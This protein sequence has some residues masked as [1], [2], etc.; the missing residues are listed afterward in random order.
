MQEIGQVVEGVYA[1]KAALELADQYEVSMPIVEG[2]NQ[3]LFSGKDPEK[4]VQDLMMRDKRSENSILKFN[5]EGTCQS[6]V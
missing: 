2:V 4:A 6:N 5:D 3:V 1:A